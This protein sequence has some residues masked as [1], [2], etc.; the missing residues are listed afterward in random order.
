MK[1]NCL[2]ICLVFFLS[3]NLNRDKKHNFDRIILKDIISEDMGI[4][5]RF[6]FNFFVKCDTQQVASLSIEHLRTI[7]KS[8]NINISFQEF[9]E[10]LLDQKDYLKEINFVDC[11]TLENAVTD[12]YRNNSLADFMH[13][14]GHNAQG[15]YRLRND[16]SKPT[17]KTVSY[18]LFLSNYYTFFDDNIGFYYVRS[19]TVLH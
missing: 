16:L 19:S 1:F 9:L 5:S 2:V 3:C 17:I 12:N 18:Y 4:P 6:T 7:Y 13:I 14:Y 10:P 11:F 8:S 15:T